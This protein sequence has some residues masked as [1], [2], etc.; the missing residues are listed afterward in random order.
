MEMIISTVDTSNL[1]GYKRLLTEEY[2]K[3]SDEEFDSVIDEILNDV[4]IGKT[5]LVENVKLFIPFSV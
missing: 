4:K 3:I 5:S 1:P 2:W